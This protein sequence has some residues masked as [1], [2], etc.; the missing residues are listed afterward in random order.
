MFGGTLVNICC[1]LFQLQVEFL[2]SRNCERGEV[3]LG[4]TQIASESIVNLLNARKPPPLLISHPED[5]IKL[6]RRKNEK[7]DAY[8]LKAFAL[9]LPLAV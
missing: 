5:S 8:D 2:V 6:D 3:G 9:S 1:N 4:K 7:H